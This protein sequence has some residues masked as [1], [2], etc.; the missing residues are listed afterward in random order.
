MTTG[1]IVMVSSFASFG[2]LLV[3]RV[4]ISRHGS[5]ILKRVLTVGTAL[6]FALFC[7]FGCSAREHNIE[8]VRRAGSVESLSYDQSSRTLYWLD[9]DG[10]VYTARRDEVEIIVVD[11]KMSGLG[12]NAL[13]FVCVADKCRVERT[14][15]L[16]LLTLEPEIVTTYWIYIPVGMVE[17]F[18]AEDHIDWSPVLFPTE[19]PTT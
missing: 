10:E 4:L 2:I 14:D 5:K 19:S 12:D 13:P 15:F 17:T 3:V 11:K 16:D 1:A 9:P 7:F 18:F 8:V 6:C